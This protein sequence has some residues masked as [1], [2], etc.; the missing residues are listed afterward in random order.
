VWGSNGTA[1]KAHGRGPWAGA[2]RTPVLQ[3]DKYHITG[4]PTAVMPAEASPE[5]QYAATERRRVL[6]SAFDGMAGKQISLIRLRYS[7]GMTFLEIAGEFGVV[8]SAVHAMHG[9]I[10]R[11]LRDRLREQGIR[12]F[13]DIF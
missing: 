6:M 12:S 1:A 7:R 11:A 2:I 10:L 4:K 9:R 3:A 13:T 5:F 8:E